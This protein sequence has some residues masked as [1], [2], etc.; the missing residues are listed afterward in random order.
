MS[1]VTVKSPSM[2]VS[3]FSVIVPL[4]VRLSS[5]VTVPPAESRVKLPVEVSI[6]PSPLTPILISS[7]C[8][9]DQRRAA[10]PK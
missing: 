2:A 8:A 10:V 9:S 3:P 1:P 5:T 6:S 7:M 4:T